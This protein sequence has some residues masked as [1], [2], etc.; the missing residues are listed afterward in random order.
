MIPAKISKVC[1]TMIATTMAQAAQAKNEVGEITRRVDEIVESAEQIAATLMERG[2]INVQDQLNGWLAVAADAQEPETV[3]VAALSFGVMPVMQTLA[4]AIQAHKV[5]SGWNIGSDFATRAARC[6]NRLCEN[7]PPK[8]VT[9][10]QLSDIAR[11]K[12]QASSNVRAAAQEIIEK[13]GS[14]FAP[15]TPSAAG[16]KPAVA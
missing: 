7:L 11:G 2:V 15:A 1:K 4:F 5:D 13:S 16:H 8:E 12:G 6:A 9:L 14:F 10:A 3:R